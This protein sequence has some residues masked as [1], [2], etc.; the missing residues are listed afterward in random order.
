[1]GQA[2]I[3][4]EENETLDASTST[5]STAAREEN[6]DLSHLVLKKER[7]E[8]SAC[9]QCAKAK[10]A[11]SVCSPQALTDADSMPDNRN[12]IQQSIVRVTVAQNTVLTLAASVAV[13]TARS[14]ELLHEV[15]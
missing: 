7:Y 13:Q 14:V 8:I 1:M 15:V 11:C 5:T 4:S 2:P 10:R 6:E 9:D 3:F 12:I